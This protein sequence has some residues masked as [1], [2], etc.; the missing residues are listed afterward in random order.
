MDREAYWTLVMDK[1]ANWT[2]VMD[3]EVYWILS[4]TK[5]LRTHEMLL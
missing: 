3:S 1:E 4:W 2:L 5:K